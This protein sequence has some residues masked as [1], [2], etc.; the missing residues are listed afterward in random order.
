MTP[1]ELR[2]RREALGLTQTSLADLLSVKQ[3]TVSAWETGTRRIPPGVEANLADAEELVAD[4]ASRAIEGVEIAAEMAD[5][6][7]FA[8]PDD[9]SLWREHP[10]MFGT[11][12]SIL[13]RVAM[14]QA[15]SECGA[16]IVTPPAPSR[17]ADGNAP[18]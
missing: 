1:I 13:H 3:A 11:I 10:E 18:A 17:A 12:P 2:C 6:V 16:P 15:A 9:E 5:P 14:G 8:W 7:I 4:L